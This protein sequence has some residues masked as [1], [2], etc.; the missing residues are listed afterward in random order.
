MT[1]YKRFGR[2]SIDNGYSA[3]PILPRG[4][5][6]GY[7]ALDGTVVAITQW[8]H[9][10]TEPPDQY[11][12]DLWSSLECGVGIACGSVI[13]VDIDIL[14]ADIAES[15]EA[16][17]LRI[18]GVKEAPTRTGR[19]PK[20]LLMYRAVD[21]IASQNMPPWWIDKAAGVKYGMEILSHGRQFVSY[22]IHPDTAREYV[23]R[24][25]SPADTPVD[26]LPE[27]SAA[28]IELIAQRYEE[29]SGV[30]RAAAPSSAAPASNRSDQAEPAAIDWILN[31]LPNEG[32]WDD[33]TRVCIAAVNAGATFDQFDA[34]SAKHPKYSSTE[35]LR[36]WNTAQNNRGSTGI[37]SLVNILS[38]HGIKLPREVRLHREPEN[39][40]IDLR[41]IGDSIEEWAPQAERPR[42]ITL[43]FDPALHGDQRRD[44]RLT[45][46]EFAAYIR[47]LSAEMRQIEALNNGATRRLWESKFPLTPFPVDVPAPSA[48]QIAE[49]SAKILAQAC[50]LTDIQVLPE[51]LANDDMLRRIE[52]LLNGDNDPTELDTPVKYGGLVVRVTPQDKPLVPDQLS[53]P[54]DGLIREFSEWNCATAPRKIMPFSVSAGIALVSTLI[55]G[56]V[57]LRTG[58]RSNVYMINVA[59]SSSGKNHAINGVQSVLKALGITTRH[60][61]GSNVTSAAAIRNAFEA[62]LG[63]REEAEEATQETG[64][65][66]EDDKRRADGTSMSK[67]LITDEFGKFWQSNSGN[68]NQHAAGIM[69]DLLTLYSA[70]NSVWTG[71]A[72][73]GKRAAEIPYPHLTILGATTTEALFAGM[74]TNTLAEGHI[75]RLNIVEVDIDPTRM[76]STIE[77]FWRG[78]ASHEIPASVVQTAGALSNWSMEHFNGPLD[79]DRAE[80]IDMD[81]GALQFI[82]DVS[83]LE[84]AVRAKALTTPGVNEQA[85][86]RMA[87]NAAKF[88]LISA[89]SRFASRVWGSRDALTPVGRP[90]VT[91]S[92][93]VWGFCLARY[94]AERFAY[95]ARRQLPS[96]DKKQSLMEKLIAVLD[97]SKDAGM[98]RSDVRRALGCANSHI[99]PLIADCL[100]EGDVI[101]AAEKTRGRASTRLFLSRHAKAAVASGKLDAANLTPASAGA[102]K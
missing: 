93:V 84:D 12:V 86:G 34:W 48:E 73:A 62:A 43:E 79:I 27:I 94:S 32:G 82:A 23:W 57:K 81:D 41:A 50:P 42:P 36:R 69:S 70:S 7:H 11:A 19:A 101:E 16:D 61:L 67:L 71:T 90:I 78:E 47:H 26:E 25:G 91:R 88:A 52:T 60:V 58:L 2:R 76:R 99:A 31:A 24:D 38:R 77:S 80:I 49:I 87:E 28:Q 29:V 100:A 17:V 18:T 44:V 63:D 53:M 14:D 95:V 15:F 65:K 89:M 56:S 22:G 9:W 30:R 75:N 66:V 97:E 5:R 13:G 33:W 92:D 83:Q 10:C 74:T 40:H 51:S 59:R 8:E 39:L 1:Y 55:G 64:K 72:M 21:A 54:P 98:R 3:I 46:A 35:T 20:R 37:G 4:K 85:F 96:A 68:Q 45:P 102:L 6:P